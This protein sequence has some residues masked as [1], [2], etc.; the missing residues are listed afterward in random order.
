MGQANMMP[1]YSFQGNGGSVYAKPAAPV[2]P[3]GTSSSMYRN[4]NK[5]RANR[6]TGSGEDDEVGAG[7]CA[8]LLGACCVLLCCCD[9]SE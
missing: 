8:C 1:R 6:V 2:Q 3:M 9:S 4:Q 7:C 5:K